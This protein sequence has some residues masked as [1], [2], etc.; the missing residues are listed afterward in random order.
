MDADATGE[1]LLG[2]TGD[3][4]PVNETEVQLCGNDWSLLVAEEGSLIYLCEELSSTI[5]AD[6][7]ASFD[8]R[9]A[10]RCRCSVPFDLS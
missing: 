4:E 6:R 8:L 10:S 7:A 9:N 1:G 3:E 5:E 2:A